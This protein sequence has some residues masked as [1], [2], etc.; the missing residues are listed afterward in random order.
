MANVN[1]AD[2]MEASGIHPKYIHL[3]RDGRDVACSFK[4]AVVGE[5]HVFH[6][7]NKWRENEK[8]C[9]KLQE[10]IEASRYIA[11]SYENITAFP[12]KELKRIC[13][14]LHI[15]FSPEVFDFYKSEESH[16]TA[17]AGKMWNNVAKPVLSNN[18]N[19]FKREL[20]EMEIAIFEKQAGSILLKLNYELSGLHLL[21]GTPFSKEQLEMFNKEN[22]RLKTE[23]I[24]FADPDGMKLRKGQETL[25]KEIQMR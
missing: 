16:K 1:F 22:K 8:A 5:K 17:V 2:E 14:F 9:F 18:S 20:S 25:L 4:K 19:K 11:V 23:A 21:N 6:I 10:Q 7:A 15:E 12:K 13:S 3:Y 24:Q